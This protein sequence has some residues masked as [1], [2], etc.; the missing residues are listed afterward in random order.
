MGLG[1][2]VCKRCRCIIQGP[3]CKCGLEFNHKNIEWLFSIPDTLWDSVYDKDPFYSKTIKK[4]LGY[5]NT[6]K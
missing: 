2:P 5:K 4:L 6:T 1:P 3:H